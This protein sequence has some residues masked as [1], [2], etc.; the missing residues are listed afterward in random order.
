M[1]EATGEILMACEIHDGFVQDVVGAHMALEAILN[2][3]PAGAEALR[4]DL[5]RVDSLLIRAIADARRVI[6]GSRPAVKDGVS[7]VEAIQDLIDMEGAVGGLAVELVH[8]VPSPQLPPP[9]IDS[10]LRI[11]HESIRN[12]R[13]HARV[14]R[15]VVRILQEADQILVEVQDEGIG[16]NPDE[17]AAGCFGLEGLCARARALG[18]QAT[19]HSAPG[20]GTRISAR[21]PSVGG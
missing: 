21:L 9:V 17:I 11:V 12:V 10:I 8:H 1:R 19:I 5:R 4:E 15:A 13:R 14:D 6:S 3:I 20:Q 16:F 2:R 18:G 7:V